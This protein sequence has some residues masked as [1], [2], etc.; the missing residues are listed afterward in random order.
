MPINGSI[1][2]SPPLE[3]NGY[4]VISSGYRKIAGDVC[5]GGVEHNEIRL[6]CPGNYSSI[7]DWLLY[8]FIGFLAYYVY[9]N[10][11]ETIKIWIFS[12][13]D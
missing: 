6:A 1:D 5:E 9:A 11:S 12:S 2:T 10:Y 8:G 7:F 13:G 4:Y 3:C